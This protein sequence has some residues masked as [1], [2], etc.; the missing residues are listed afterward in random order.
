MTD[1]D[2][3]EARL[4]TKNAATDTRATVNKRNIKRVS[5]DDAA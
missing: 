2:A 5:Q 4:T 1:G 3:T